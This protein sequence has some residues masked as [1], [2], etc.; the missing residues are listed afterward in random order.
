[1]KIA[2]VDDIKE[3]R[4]NMAQMAKVCFSANGYSEAETEQFSCGEAFLEKF[5]TGKYDVIFLDIFMGGINGIKT[6]EK[7]RQKDC[8]VKIIFVTTSNDFASESYF[9]KADG[10]LLKPYT[11]ETFDYMVKQINLD[12]LESTRSIQFSDGQSALLCTVVYTSYYGHYVSVYLT[13]GEVIKVRTSHDSFIKW[14]SSYQ[15]LFCCNKGLMV[16]LQNV[17]NLDEDCFVMKGDARVPISRRKLTDAKKI[18]AE[19]LV[20]QIRKGGF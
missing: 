18:Y 3:E 9:V 2:V 7:I 13:T 16:N 20:S 10:Y 4:E 5:Y 15:Q 12:S 11:A 8:A 17:I 1:M 19:Y 14:V 6:A